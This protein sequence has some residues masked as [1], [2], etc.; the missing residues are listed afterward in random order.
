MPQHE[1]VVVDT[2]PE[3]GVQAGRGDPGR[4]AEEAP[5]DREDQEGRH[6]GGGDLEQRERAHQV[7]AKDR[8]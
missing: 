2:G 5:A 7:G 8:P 3:N 4:L 6:R 1:N